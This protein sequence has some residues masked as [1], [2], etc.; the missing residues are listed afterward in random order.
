M[1]QDLSGLDSLLTDIAGGSNLKT[2]MIRGR[3]A[4]QGI[5]AIGRWSGLEVLKLPLEHTFVQMD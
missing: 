1:L 5:E 4:T 3:L 2:L